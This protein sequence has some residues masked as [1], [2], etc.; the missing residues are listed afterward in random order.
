MNVRCL[1]AGGGTGGHTF[2]GVAVAE[3]LEKLHSGTQIMWLGTGRPVERN[4]LENKEWSYRVLDVKPLYGHG[5][6]GVLMAMLALPLSILRAFLIIRAFDPDVVLGV[7]GYVSGPVI[8]AARMAGKKVVIHEQNLVPGLANRWAARFANSIFTSFEASSG[9]FPERCRGKITCKGNPVR[10]SLLES[11]NFSVSG[12]RNKEPLILVLGGS[13]GAAGLNRLVASALQG[14]GK[15]GVIF[16]VIHQAGPGRVTE[17]GRF[18]QHMNDRVNVVEFI[19]DMGAAY[20][21]ADLVVCRAGATTIAELTALGKPSVL[22]PYPYSA[23]GHQDANA[24]FMSERGAALYFQQA[25]T[26][27]VMLGSEIDKLLKDK[28]RLDSMG[29]N[30]K[31]SGRPYA[32]MD[33]ADS[34]LK[35]MTEEV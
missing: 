6:A 3:A 32:A 34:L 11:A 28:K 2:P 26:G 17:T 30:A 12:R 15:S 9:Y 18:Y 16:R 1:I 13:Q 35:T 4:A 8:V 5:L 33:I 22:I 29:E 19:D 10:L 21:R 23:E 14:L 20:R 27:A 7:G 25:D 24:R 31:R